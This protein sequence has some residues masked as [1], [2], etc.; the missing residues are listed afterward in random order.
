MFLLHLKRRPGNV[1]E[2]RCAC[3]YPPTWLLLQPNLRTSIGDAWESSLSVSSLNRNK[4]VVVQFS[5]GCLVVFFSAVGDSQA[6]SNSS[7]FLLKFWCSSSVVIVTVQL[8][9]GWMWQIFHVKENC[10]NWCLNIGVWNDYDYLN[11]LCGSVK[12]SLSNDN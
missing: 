12:P 5:F 1:R 10:R 11:S 3:W 7:F 9:A 6:R 8:D 4:W 2:C